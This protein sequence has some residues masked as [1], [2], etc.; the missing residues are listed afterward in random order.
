[1]FIVIHSFLAEDQNL[2]HQVDAIRAANRFLDMANQSQH[3]GRGRAAGIDD[4]ARVL[5]GDFGP[6]DTEAFEAGFSIMG[7]TND[8][9]DG[10]RCCRRSAFPTV[11]WKS[12]DG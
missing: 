6:A 3:V 4:E 2:R 8:L 1:M 11:V 5:A 10:G 7:P 9:R 12:G